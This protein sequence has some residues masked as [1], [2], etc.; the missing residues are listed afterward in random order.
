MFVWKI[1]LKYKM[2]LLKHFNSN[3]LMFQTKIDNLDPKTEIGK[4][5]EKNLKSTLKMHK[6]PKLQQI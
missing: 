5:W 3:V 6:N 1:F 2:F 4:K